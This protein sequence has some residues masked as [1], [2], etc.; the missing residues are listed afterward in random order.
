MHP[1]LTF[2]GVVFMFCSLQAKAFQCETISGSLSDKIRTSIQMTTNP[3]SLSSEGIATSDQG[4]KIYVLARIIKKRGLWTEGSS[5]ANGASLTLGVVNPQ[6]KLGSDTIASVSTEGIKKGLNLA[7]LKLS[8]LGRINESS[9]IRVE[10]R[11]E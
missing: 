7:N 11:G 3:I 6:S 1:I 4:V 5:A 8:A 9:W 2:I 10:C